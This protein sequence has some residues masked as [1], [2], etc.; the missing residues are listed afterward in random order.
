MI[1]L[2]VMSIIAG[3]AVSGFTSIG[4]LFW[5]TGGIVFICGLLFALI[6]SFVHSEVSY[7][8]DRADYREAMAEI[9]AEELADEHEFAED[10]RVD[11]LAG[12]LKPRTAIYN[13]NRQV[14]LHG[15][16]SRTGDSQKGA[17]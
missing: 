10:T 7:A 14:Y 5:L 8:Q 4:F 17:Y 3:A 15:M 9:K 1:T 6:S 16:S 13:D 2:L 12:S 11:R